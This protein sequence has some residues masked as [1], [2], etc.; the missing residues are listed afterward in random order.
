[1]PKVSLKVYRSAVLPALFH[2]RRQATA[3]SDLADIAI[4][5]LSAGSPAAPAKLRED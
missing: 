4:G 3:A 2:S 5:P 1:L